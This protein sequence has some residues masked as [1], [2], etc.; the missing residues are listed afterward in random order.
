M[1]FLFQLIVFFSISFFLIT[2][3]SIAQDTKVT[4]STDLSQMD[5]SDEPEEESVSDTDLSQMTWDD[6][7]EEEEGATENLSEMSWEDEE[8]ETDEMDEEETF[9]PLTLED[10]AARESRERRT[11]VFG[12]LLFI[13]YI[14]CGV[15]TA[16]FT[17][18][19]KLAVDYPPEL[20]MLLHTFWPIEWIFMIFAGKKVR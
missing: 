2:P 14:L 8:G 7:P 3:L 12:F 15:L 19:R 10:E 16:F 17:R 20:L 1:K 5:W 4:D 6:E 11:H 13:G 18:N 9:E